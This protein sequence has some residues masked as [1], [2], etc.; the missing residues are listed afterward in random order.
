MYNLVSF[1]VGIFTYFK[2]LQ[3]Q[4]MQASRVKWNKVQFAFLAWKIA[5]NMH[6]YAL[7]HLHLTYA[8][9]VH[10]NMLVLVVPSVACLNLK[11]AFLIDWWID[12]FILTF[13]SIVYCPL[14]TVY[15]LLFTVHCPLSIIYCL[16]ST[17]HCL[18]S[19]V[20][21]LLSTVCLLSTYSTVCRN[22]NYIWT[23]PF[24]H[25]WV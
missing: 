13:L 8:C 3:S 17:I 7:L 11:Q 10:E 23:L 9:R 6:V 18:L 2:C 22:K 25:F 12:L 19:T 15:C 20:H 4:C 16:L 21:C 1:C 24:L 14:F 5:S